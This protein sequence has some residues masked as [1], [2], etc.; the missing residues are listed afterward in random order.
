MRKP[1]T[2]DYL[3]QHLLF[4]GGRGSSIALE[5]RNVKAIKDKIA[6]AWNTDIVEVVILCSRVWPV[7]IVGAV[8]TGSSVGNLEEIKLVDHVSDLEAFD[9]ILLADLDDPQAAYENLANTI[10]R[11]K[12]YI[13]DFMNVSKNSPKLKKERVAE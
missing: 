12:I 5:L 11:N 13:P 9:A 2:A 7:T 8:I 3:A 6:I 4:L 1:L 10:G